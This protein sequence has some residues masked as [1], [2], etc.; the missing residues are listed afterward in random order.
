[1]KKRL[2][3]KKDLIDEICDYVNVGALSKATLNLFRRDLQRM[4]K[5][6]LSVVLVILRNMY[7]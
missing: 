7:V 2:R 5:P 1:M 6:G 3:L 4:S